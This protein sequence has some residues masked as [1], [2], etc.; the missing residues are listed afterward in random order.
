MTI[1]TETEHLYAIARELAQSLNSSAQKF[2]KRIAS[3]V[4]ER[5]VFVDV[6]SV[7]HFYAKDKLTYAST[8]SKDYV[9]DN[10]ISE[11][12]EK[13]LDPDQDSD[14]YSKTRQL[15]REKYGGAKVCRSKSDSCN[16]RGDN[17]GKSLKRGRIKCALRPQDRR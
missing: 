3:R 9:I 6:G 10:T 14:A 1:P 2:P 15:A 5:V 12:E 8:S 4:G 7:T 16:P 11:L 13:L 17:L